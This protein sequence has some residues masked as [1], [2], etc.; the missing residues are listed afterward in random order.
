MR[1]YL[2]LRYRTSLLVMLLLL[3]LLLLLVSRQGRTHHAGACHV[4]PDPSLVQHAGKWM[5]AATQSFYPRLRG[6]TRTPASRAPCCSPGCQDNKLKTVAVALYRF[7]T[8]GHG[9]CL[10]TALYAWR[11]RVERRFGPLT[12]F[13]QLRRI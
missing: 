5:P 1:S 8:G 7:F 4:S 10:D 6:G 3:L 9:I 2:A 13:L 11:V 12:Y